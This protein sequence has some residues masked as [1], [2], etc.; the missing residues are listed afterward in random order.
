MGKNAYAMRLVTTKDKSMLQ[1][2]SR[3]KQGKKEITF[4]EW[5]VIASMVRVSRP[6]S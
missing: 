5:Q 1:S 4:T 3:T 2:L 6:K